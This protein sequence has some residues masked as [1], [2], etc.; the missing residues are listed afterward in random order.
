MKIGELS[1]QTGVSVDTIRYYE[2]R[3]LIPAAERLPSGYRQYVSGD[4]SRLKFIVQAKDLGFTL[5]EIGQLLAI[6]ADDR[7]CDEVRA[8]A[9]A[10][11]AEID[12]RIRKLSRMR[13][14][15]LTLAEQCEQTSDTN[16]CPIL[17]SLEEMP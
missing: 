10:K 15:L 7:A 1:R 4:V 13:Q 9:E 2:Q 8:V 17:K 14:T 5:E 16:P 3:G 6:R 11:A 12:G